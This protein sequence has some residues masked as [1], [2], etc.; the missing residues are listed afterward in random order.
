MK[1]TGNAYAFLVAL[2]AAAGGFLFGFD[3]SIASGALPFLKEQF[4][5]DA[6]GEGLAMSSAIFGSIAGPLAGMWLAD[7]VGRRNTLWVA[8][9]CFLASAI[10]TA[11]PRTILEF[12]VWRAV[13]GIGV[14]LAAMTSPMYIAELSP[15]RLRG[16][17][18]TVNQLA[19]VIGINLAVISSWL[20]S[21]G[22]HWRWMFASEIPA[23]IAL[24]A[25]LL[26]VPESPRWLAAKGRDDEALDVLGRINGP[27][28]AARELADI[29]GELTE[30]SGTFAELFQPGIRTAVV[31]GVILMIYQQVNGVNM[32]LLYGPS[33]LQNAGIGSAS[34]AIFFTIF[35]NLFILVATIVA[36]G[37]VRR[38]GRRQ[39]LM[40]GVT[41]MAAGHLLMAA[42]F[43]R[44]G[45][46]F[47]SLAAM[48]LAAASFTLSLAPVGWIV[49]SE[50]YPN[51]IRATAL[52]VVCFL[53]YLASFLCA[54]YFPMLTAAC[55]KRMGHPGAAY[56]IFAGI[57]L[58]CVAF[59]WRW[60]PET[61]DL[62][63]EKIGRF[64]LERSRP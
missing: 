52:A 10:G 42:N 16:R 48:A 21:F 35:L 17:L 63:L 9:A 13:G 15:P 29:R 37:L 61:K 18:V 30:E 62:P 8:A 34:D 47:V 22:G 19:I 41:G 4:G 24:M 28:A 5:L 43:F 3:L 45:S 2:V 51:R 20:L 50:I 25:G 60:L 59:V 57:C 7:R 56:L 14:G 23:I 44:G 53:L 38:F 32:M 26:F 49:V 58:S 54:Q 36:F 64:W 40:A 11:L 46:P 33:I 27:D 1:L 55:E 39:I 12:N 6:A 31:V